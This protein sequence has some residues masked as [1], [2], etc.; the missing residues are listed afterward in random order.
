MLNLQDDPKNLRE[1]SAMW[2]TSEGWYVMNGFDRYYYR[3]D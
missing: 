1:G 2:T 3:A